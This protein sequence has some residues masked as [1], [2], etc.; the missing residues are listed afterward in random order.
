M[1]ILDLKECF[2]SERNSSQGSFLK[3]LA[4]SNHP[5]IVK[6][7][8]QKKHI[9]GTPVF[10]KCKEIEESVLN[11]ILEVLLIEPEAD[12]FWYGYPEYGGQLSYTVPSYGEVAVPGDALR[13]DKKKMKAFLRDYKLEKLGI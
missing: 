6:A 13:V 2:H 5:E 11:Q 4:N 1:T 3:F 10:D 9:S 12:Y 8:E 7:K